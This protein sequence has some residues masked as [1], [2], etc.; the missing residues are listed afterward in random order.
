M[1]ATK[2]RWALGARHPEA[3]RAPRDATTGPVGRSGTRSCGTAG[4]STCCARPPLRYGPSGDT[5]PAPRLGWQ[6]WALRPGLDGGVPADHDAHG[7][8]AGRRIRGHPGTVLLKADQ[9]RRRPS[10]PGARRVPRRA[11]VQADSRST[12]T[13]TGKNDCRQAAKVV[14]AEHGSAPPRRYWGEPGRRRHPKRGT[15]SAPRTRGARGRKPAE[16]GNEKPSPG[17]TR[18]RPRGRGVE[19]AEARKPR[20]PDR[21]TP[22][23]AGLNRSHPSPRARS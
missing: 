17:T 20:V 1:A 3:V 21:Q 8:A 2:P 23:Q 16:S 11:P 19:P 6:L 10:E 18:A 22:P 4:V 13:A 12:T 15:E 14:D 7:D 5:P 9:R